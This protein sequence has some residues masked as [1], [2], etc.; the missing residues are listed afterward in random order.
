LLASGLAGESNMTGLAI[1]CAAGS[2]D[3]VKGAFVWVCWSGRVVESTA[4]L[5]E[6]L[7]LSNLPGCVK[8]ARLDGTVARNQ[9]FSI[10]SN[11]WTALA[12]SMPGFKLLVLELYDTDYPAPFTTY[13]QP[14]VDPERP[15]KASPPN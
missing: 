3:N 1:S 8:A 5:Y 4:R 13:E 11:T 2:C 12:G 14:V 6:F 9:A 7:T 10:S 15:V